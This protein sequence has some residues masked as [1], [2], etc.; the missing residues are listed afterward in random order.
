MDINIPHVTM[1]IN[2]QTSGTIL[3]HYTY[4][5]ILYINWTTIRHKTLVHNLVLNILDINTCTDPEWGLSLLD[6]HTAVGRRYTS[7]HWWHTGNGHVTEYKQTINGRVICVIYKYKDRLH[8]GTL[9]ISTYIKLYRTIY[10]YKLSTLYVG[11]TYK[12][13]DGLGYLCHTQI[14]PASMKCGHPITRSTGCALPVY[15]MTL[16]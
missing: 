9:H 15:R 13:T 1:E 10:Y 8:F 7:D 11:E 6:T 4:T 12:M 5:C 2:I 3:S 16:N 14:K